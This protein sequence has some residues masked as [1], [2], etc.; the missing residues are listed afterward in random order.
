[1][2]AD[3]LQPLLGQREE[4]IFLAGEVA[5]NG[6]RAIFNL[7]GNF[8]HRHAGVALIEEQRPRRI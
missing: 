1:M 4:D 8:A 5:V 6:S 2:R 7:F 3:D